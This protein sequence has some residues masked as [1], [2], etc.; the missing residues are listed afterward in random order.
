MKSKVLPIIYCLFVC[1][2]SVFSQIESA[3]QI[4][5]FGELN[6]ED[7]LSRSDNL[8]NELNENPT[9]ISY[10]IF[11]EG[12]HSKYSYNKRPKNLKANWLIQDAARLVTKQKLSDFI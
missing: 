5:A 1:A 2:L 3:K 7:I 6:C 10:I 12:K 11:Y 4:D 9:T 8:L